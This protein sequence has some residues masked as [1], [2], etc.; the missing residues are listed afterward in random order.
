MVIPPKTF[1]RHKKGYSSLG[2]ILSVG[3]VFS[4][5]RK[6]VTLHFPHNDILR[7]WLLRHIY[8]SAQEVDFILLAAVCWMGASLKAIVR[9]LSCLSTLILFTSFCSHFN[10][11][12]GPSISTAKYL[13][14]L[15]NKCSC[16]LSC[17]FCTTVL[18]PLFFHSV[19][20][21]SFNTLYLHVNLVSA[22]S[23]W[24]NIKNLV[25]TQLC[26]KQG[27]CYDIRK[28][29]NWEVGLK[30]LSNDYLWM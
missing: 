28:C 13:S 26:C 29:L 9:N 5:K 14:L 4:Y 15:Q 16:I 17:V 6:P 1:L 2:P 22:L 24:V 3:P 12:S 23:W 10:C 25:A 8:R 20:S 27:K 7:L 11:F 19:W 21:W 30:N 18:S